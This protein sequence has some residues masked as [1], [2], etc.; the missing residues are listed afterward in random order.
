MSLGNRIRQ[1]FGG[2]QSKFS[3]SKESAID[4]QCIGFSKS[5]LFPL[6]HNGEKVPMFRLCGPF[7]PKFM[8]ESFFPEMVTSFASR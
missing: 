2:T 6:S 8:G 1:R 7:T 5:L 3:P 4:Y